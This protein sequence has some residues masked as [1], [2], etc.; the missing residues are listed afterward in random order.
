MQKNIIFNKN[1]LNENGISVDQV[2][3]T[4]IIVEQVNQTGN[5]DTVFQGLC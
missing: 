3:A 5:L 4:N 1:F 2:N